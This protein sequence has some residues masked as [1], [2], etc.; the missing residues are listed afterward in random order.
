[1]GDFTGNFDV[2]CVSPD[3]TELVPENRDMIVEF[4]LTIEIKNVGT[5]AAGLAHNNKIIAVCEDVG[6]H[7][8]FDKVI[9]TCL[10]RSIP[11]Q[12]SA[13]VLSGRVSLELIIKAA[14]AGIELIAAVS[15]PTTLAIQAAKQPSTATNTES[16][17]NKPHHP[18]Q[19]I[20]ASR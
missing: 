5:H 4:L 20:I 18:G 2:A 9:G 19:H 10:L 11:T 12:S 13:A 8:A 15:A 16:L 14:R 3:S 6:R 1:M 17:T 7:N